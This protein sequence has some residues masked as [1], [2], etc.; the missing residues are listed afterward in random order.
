MEIRGEE[1]GLAHTAA[2]LVYVKT[3][4]E[5]VEKKRKEERERKKNSH[6]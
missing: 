6:I 1:C 4:Q 2:P 5:Q 3:K